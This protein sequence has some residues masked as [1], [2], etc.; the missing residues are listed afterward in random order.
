MNL[1]EGIKLVI[2]CPKDMWLVYNSGSVAFCPVTGR[3]AAAS[4]LISFVYVTVRRKEN[5]CR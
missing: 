1:A 3:A 4:A 5:D 2:I